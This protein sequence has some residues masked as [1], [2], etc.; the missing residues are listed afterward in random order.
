M[1]GRLIDHCIYLIRE[2]KLKGFEANEIYENTKELTYVFKHKDAQ[3]NDIEPD[4]DGSGSDLEE[5]S[6]D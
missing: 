2:S 3:G 4:F 1:R 6:Y 5:T